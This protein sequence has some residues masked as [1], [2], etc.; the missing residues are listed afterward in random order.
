MAEFALGQRKFRTRS[1]SAVDQWRV[2]RRI[3]AVLPTFIGM[4]V[5]LATRGAAP[6]GDLTRAIASL[7]DEDA[8]QALAAGRSACEEFDGETWGDV[9]PLPLAE[10]LALVRTVAT[11]NFTAFQVLE[12]PSFKPIPNDLPDYEPVHMP[13]DE[14]W[15]FRP[16]MRGMCKAEGMYDGT[17]KLEHIAKMNDVLDVLD[18]NHARAQNALERARA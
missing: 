2:F 17:L 13:N 9:K 4:E 5:G 7:S 18:E 11:E 15:L 14:D 3:Q 1:L 6:L 12:R 8:E 16:L 10:T